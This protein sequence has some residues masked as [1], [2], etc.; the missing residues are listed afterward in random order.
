MQDNRVNS[1]FDLDITPL[2]S[3]AEMCA[4]LQKSRATVHRWVRAQKLIT[5]IR[6]NQRTLGWCPDEFKRW[7]SD[8]GNLPLN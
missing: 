4:I 3:I 5:P 2:I 1:S 7:Q 6:R 8:Q